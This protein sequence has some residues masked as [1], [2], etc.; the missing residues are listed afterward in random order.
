MKQIVSHQSLDIWIRVLVNDH[1]RVGVDCEEFT[2]FTGI[3]KCSTAEMEK[4][5]AVF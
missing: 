3:L 2:S 5:I 1:I 4:N